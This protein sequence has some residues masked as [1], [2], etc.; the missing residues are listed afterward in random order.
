MPGSGHKAT[1]IVPVR[2]SRNGRRAHQ[3][4]RAE[5]QALVGISGM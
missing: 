2:L 5:E 4:R 3:R 1:R